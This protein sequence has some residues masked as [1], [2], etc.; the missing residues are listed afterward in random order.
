MPVVTV[1]SSLFTEEEK[2]E[3]DDN[4]DLAGIGV[5]EVRVDS[6]EEEEEE[7]II[8]DDAIGFLRLDFGKL[9]YRRSIP[10][11]YIIRYRGYGYHRD[12]GIIQ[13]TGLTGT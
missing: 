5:V 1:E 6:A 7:D 10:P 9:K 4:D 8:I 3:D 2:N 13:K 12:K 11:K